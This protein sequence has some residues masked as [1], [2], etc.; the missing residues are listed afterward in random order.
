MPKC[1]NDESRNYK[2]DEP[3]PKGLGY[4]AHA[5]KEGSQKKG[6]DGNMWI[7]SRT[8]TGTKRWNKS[9]GKLNNDEKDSKWIDNRLAKI[10]EEGID[11]LFKV[12]VRS[13]DDVYEFTIERN[14]KYAEFDWIIDIYLVSSNKIKEGRRNPYYVSKKPKKPKKPV[15]KNHEVKKKD[16]Q[17]MQKN[18]K[19]IYTID[20][21]DQPYITLK[22]ILAQKAT[23][24]VY[25]QITITLKKTYDM[26]N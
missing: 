2:G 6:K 11:K 25:N 15:A 18:N 8:K 1:K 24:K 20:D 17:S 10:R 4:C 23:G 7:V 21:V 19:Y 26:S 13:K 22:I 3:S 16:F 14:K 12:K 9:I 5:E